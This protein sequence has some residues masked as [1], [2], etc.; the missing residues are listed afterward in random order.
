MAIV[1]SGAF[2]LKKIRRCYD[3]IVE[4]REWTWVR[5]KQEKYRQDINIIYVSLK[6]LYKI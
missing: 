5:W 1:Y 6:V 3:N 2:N 4:Q